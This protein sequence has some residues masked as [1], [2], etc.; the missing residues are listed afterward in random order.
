MGKYSECSDIEFLNSLP[1]LKSGDVYDR[2]KVLDFLGAYEDDAKIH[3]KGTFELKDC[4]FW[5]EHSLAWDITNC[6]QTGAVREIR[7][8][9][10]E[11]VANE[12]YY[13]EPLETGKRECYVRK[14]KRFLS[15][16]DKN[17]FLN[18]T[19]E[20]LPLK[21]Q[22]LQDV[23][24]GVLKFANEEKAKTFKGEIQRWND[25]RAGNIS[26]KEVLAIVKKNRTEL[27]FC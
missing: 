8:A 1:S 6:D 15:A 22:F 3:T 7:M 19:V 21:C 13:F 12:K 17:V 23:I 9:L 18:E 26:E 16:M 5:R 4:C 10:I 20:D 27:P 24:F 2:E 25:F 11:A 14:F